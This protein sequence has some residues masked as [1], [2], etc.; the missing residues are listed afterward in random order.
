M[1]D[2]GRSLCYGIELH[3]SHLERK[4]GWEELMRIVRAVAADPVVRQLYPQLT[5]RAL[6]VR[7]TGPGRL[8]GEYDPAA[9][10]IRV[11]MARQTDLTIIHE[12]AHACFGGLEEKSHG[13]AWRECF[14]LLLHRHANNPTLV[15]LVHGMYVHTH[16]LTTE[17]GR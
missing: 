7:P 3:F 17:K 16:A 11:S 10:R 2:A 4:L 9:H 1:R 6:K 15:T 12:L 14:L 5:R 8:G 13:L